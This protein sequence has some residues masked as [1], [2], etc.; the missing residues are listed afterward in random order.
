MKHFNF[1]RGHQMFENLE[2][3]N[4]EWDYNI[5]AISTPQRALQSKIII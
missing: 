2:S 4:I 1:K 3:I 5:W